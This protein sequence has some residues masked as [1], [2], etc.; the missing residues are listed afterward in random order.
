[1]KGLLSLKIEDLGSLYEAYMPFIDKGGIF[2][3]TQ[4]SYK[5]GDEIFLKLQ[6]PGEHGVLP[7]PGKVIWITP[8]GAQ[9]R[10]T[11]GIGVQLLDPVVHA[12]VETLLAGALE[13]GKPTQTM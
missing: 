1:M 2:I 5:M 6:L 13:S 10:R 11:A 4:K 7:V 8:K 3:P 9:N 12:K